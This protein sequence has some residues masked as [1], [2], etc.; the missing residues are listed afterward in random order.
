MNKLLLLSCTVAAALLF[1]G[2]ARADDQA[3]AEADPLAALA[4]LGDSLAMDGPE[5]GGSIRAKKDADLTVV[6]RLKDKRN[7]LAKV[8]QIKRAAFPWIALKLKV[9]KP[10]TEGAHKAAVKKNDE[11]VVIPTLKLT[12]KA[13]DLSD[14]ATLINAGAFYLQS[15][16][17]VMVRLTETRGKKWLAEYIERK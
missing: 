9:V 4:E 5:A 3:A 8:V 10:A 16:D 14:P 1:T 12:A 6:K 13:P 17:Q 15:G 2:V 7:L 11:I